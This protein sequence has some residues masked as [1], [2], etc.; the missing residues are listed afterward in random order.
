MI[1]ESAIA[2]NV[3]AIRDRIGRDRHLMAVVKADAYGHG[4]IRVAQT[5]LEH[6]ADCLGVAIPEEGFALR[7]AGINAPILVFG[8][9][10][11]QEAG[12][13][14]AAKLDQSVGSLD[15]LDSLDRAG[16]NAGSDV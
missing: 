3:A 14:V 13:V 15:L 6:G 8:F 4:A 11:P 16:K 1:D 9:I 12:K 7:Q 10:Q 5:A 2:F